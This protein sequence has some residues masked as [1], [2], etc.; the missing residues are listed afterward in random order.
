M[1][2]DF[3]RSPVF[4]ALLDK[5]QDCFRKYEEKAQV[6]TILDDESQDTP[7]SIED[8]WCRLLESTTVPLPDLEKYIDT[9]SLSSAMGL[10]MIP[11]NTTGRT[12]ELL[13]SL[14]SSKEKDLY[15]QKVIVPIQQFFLQQFQKTAQLD[16]LHALLWYM[17]THSSNKIL[18]RKCD[19]FNDQLARKVCSSLRHGYIACGAGDTEK[20]VYHSL[21]E[22][23]RLFAQKKIKCFTPAAVDIIN[24]ASF[25]TQTQN[26]KIG[27][28]S[29]KAHPILF[30]TSVR[31]VPYKV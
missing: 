27:G 4:Q 15:H 29:S 1:S 21:L 2:S 6:E 7:W 5:G 10:G 25:Q 18:Q 3:L 11:G 17:W 26:Q 16:T 24:T 23:F 30:K 9:D 13:T 12:L 14:T 19:F 28:K 31:C 20:T 8:K 22:A